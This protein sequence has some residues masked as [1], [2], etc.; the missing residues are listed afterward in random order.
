MRGVLGPGSKRKR[1]FCARVILDILDEPAPAVAAAAR[2]VGWCPRPELN[3]NHTFRKRDGLALS[4]ERSVHK[5]HK[6]LKT[7]QNFGRFWQGLH[8]GLCHAP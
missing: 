7:R 8:S 1:V 2:R 6:S 4:E 5:T 3:W